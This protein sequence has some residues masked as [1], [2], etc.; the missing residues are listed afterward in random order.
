LP[1]FLH[2]F[3]TN[4]E[5]ATISKFRQETLNILSALTFTESHL[6]FCE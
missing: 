2:V 5:N 6:A 1:Y 4:S 3:F